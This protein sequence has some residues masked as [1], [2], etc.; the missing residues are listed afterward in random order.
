VDDPPAGQP[1]RDYLAQIAEAPR[2]TA[3]Q[4]AELDVRIGAGHRAERQDL[5]RL[6][7][8][9]RQA[10]TRAITRHGRPTQLPPA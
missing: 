9:G 2:L 7:E 5:E 3:G 4:E 6:A 1:V 8:D 10:I